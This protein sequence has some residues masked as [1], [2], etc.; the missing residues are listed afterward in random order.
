MN[1]SEI[2]SETQF[3]ALEP[4]WNRVA[5]EMDTPSPFQSW[6][7]Q[8]LWWKHFGNGHRLRILVFREDNRTVGIAPLY[9]HRLGFGSVQLSLLTS[10]GW[11]DYRRKRGVTERC[12][13]LWPG[14]VKNQSFEA[15]GS[16]LNEAN[17]QALLLPDVEEGKELPPTLGRYLVDQGDPLVFA[18][19]DLPAD[20]EAF[21]ASLSKSMRGNIRYY[22]RLLARAGYSYRFDVAE[23]PEDAS[24]ALGLLLALHR[25][26]SQVR[27]SVMHKD[28]FRFADRRSFITDVVPALSRRGELK[29]GLLIVG[30]ET[31]AAQMWLEKCGAMFLYYSGYLPGWAKYSVG[32]VAT[33]ETL[34]VGIARGL[35][36]VDFLIGMG[37]D[38]SR[39]RTERSQYRNILLARSPRLFT[40]ALALR[41]LVRVPDALRSA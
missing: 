23:G 17:W 10:I 4:D 18:H 28:K 35:H 8:R 9:E 26:R 22:P 38:K 11:E 5:A 21:L 29:I 36:T 24:R 16:W 7:W 12:G 15:L 39:W 34:K 1:I 32:L 31:V 30:N 33:I 6:Q 14:H 40:P 3:D 19:R 37:Q 2:T 20:W 25:A 27:G 13:F 41:A